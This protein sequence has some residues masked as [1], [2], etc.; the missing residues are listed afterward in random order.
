MFGQKNVRPETDL[1][2]V[3]VQL[4]VFLHSEGLDVY[5]VHMAD[6]ACRAGTHTKHIVSSGA[7][8]RI[9]GRYLALAPLT[10]KTTDGSFCPVSVISFYDRLTLGWTLDKCQ[11][12]DGASK[13]QVIRVGW[14]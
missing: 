8:L 2:V 11:S 12:S 3:S 7:V 5:N 4:G 10:C 13:I 14:E 6:L 9:R 1:T